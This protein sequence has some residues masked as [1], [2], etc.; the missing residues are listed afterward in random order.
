[1]PASQLAL[2]NEVEYSTAIAIELYTDFLNEYPESPL[3]RNNLALRL[4]EAGSLDQAVEM[5]KRATEQ[6]PG[7]PSVLDTYGW[8]LFQ[9][10]NAAAAVQVLSTAAALAPGNE[11]IAGHLEEARKSL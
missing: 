7:N 3:V 11:T 5:A 8:L 9:A 2:I 4:A 1:M 6:A 10:G